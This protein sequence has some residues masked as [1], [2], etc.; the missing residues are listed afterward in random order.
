M[1]HDWRNNFLHPSEIG[2]WVLH[3]AAKPIG[4]MGEIGVLL[5]ST[6]VS[7]ATKEKLDDVR[8]CINYHRDVL[9]YPSYWLVLHLVE[10]LASEETDS[11]FWPASTASQRLGLMWRYTGIFEPTLGRQFTNPA[12][13]NN[14]ATKMVFTEEGWVA[15]G[16]S[17]LKIDDYIKSE[18]Y[19]VSSHFQPLA[20][21]RRRACRWRIKEGV[22]MSCIAFCPD[23]SRLARAEGSL[24]VICD[25]RTGFVQSTLTGHSPL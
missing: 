25:A 13:A 22:V 12:L 16:I 19:S 8:A 4:L 7:S 9:Q 24:M 20:Q 23:G 21:T 1:S 14:L 17:D 6:A 11:T 18:F 15:F 10:Q 3:C 2:C 5:S